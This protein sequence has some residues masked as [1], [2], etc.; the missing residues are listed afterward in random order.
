MTA[1]SKG[2]MRRRGAPQAESVGIGKGNFRAKLGL[3]TRREA[4]SEGRLGIDGADLFGEFHDQLGLG[5]FELALD[6]AALGRVACVVQ[7]GTHFFDVLFDR[8]GF[9]SLSS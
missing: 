2:E 1:L 3:I 7:L 4:A 9:I 5:E 6:L 8:H